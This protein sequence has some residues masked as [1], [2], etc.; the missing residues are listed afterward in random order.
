MNKLTPAGIQNLFDSFKGF[1]ALVIGDVM[2]DSYIYGKVE[3][4]SPEAPVPVVHISRREKRPGGA[5]NVAINIKALGAT[6]IL[7]SVTGDDDQGRD[8]IQLMQQ[9]GLKVSG[10]MSSANH[11]TTVKTRVIGNNHQLLRVDDEVIKDLSGETEQRFITMCSELIRNEKPDVIIFEDYDKGV[12]TPKV[13]SDITALAGSLK[14]PVT[15]DPK[16]K[17]FGYYNHVTL[18]KPNLS[19]LAAGLNLSKI[20]PENGSLKKAVE[21]LQS[22]KD[23]KMVMVTLSEAGVFITEGENAQ[24][25]PAHIRNISDVSGAGDTVISVAS[26]CVAAKQTPYIIAEL[27]NLAGGLVCE[28]VGVVPVN[29]NRLMQEAIKH[30]AETP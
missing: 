16:K 3:R 23:M 29:R 17:N 26:L 4:I 7:C 21:Q 15:V 24:I 13:I 30:L 2:I 6:P 20:H 19:E 5:A 11:L 10:I 27:S 25:V 28:E 22:G 14:I 18:F 9:E 1:K 8:F 12:I